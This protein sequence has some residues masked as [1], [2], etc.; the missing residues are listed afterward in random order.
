MLS[1]ALRDEIRA[2][3]IAAADRTYCQMW[4]TDVVSLP[5][6]V[7]AT[8][9]LLERLTATSV[10]RQMQSLGEQQPDKLFLLVVEA[11]ASIYRVTGREWDRSSETLSAPIAQVVFARSELASVIFRLVQRLFR[12]L[13]QIESAGVETVNVTI[14]AGELLPSDSP[15]AALPPGMFF[16]PFFRYLDRQ[17]HVRSIQTVPWT[18]LRLNS[19][20]RAK[21]VCDL[22]T[23]LRM[24]LG[25]GRRRR[26]EVQAI[27]LHATFGQTRLELVNQLNRSKRLVGYRVLVFNK[28]PQPRKE[29]DQTVLPQPLIMLS[30]RDGTVVI[31]VEPDHPVRWVYVQSGKNLLAR[32]PI[33]PGVERHMTIAVPDDSLQ[34]RVQG[35]LTR[36]ET[37]LIDVVAQ[38][39]VLMALL[40]KFA[41]AGKWQQVDKVLAELDKLPTKRYFQSEL[42][43]IRFPAVTEAEKRRLR[44]A[45]LRIEKECRDVAELIDHHLDDSKLRDVKSEVDEL[46]KALQKDQ[47]KS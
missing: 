43:A 25:S 41:E 19:T 11:T 24:P 33:V 18:Y 37:R 34:L 47:R 5:W 35:Q 29:G 17:Y 16:Q 15:D 32:V 9:A 36:L 14:R 27:A 4:K 7:P 1:P 2:E 31:P 20:N 10:K 8:G 22:V 3:L 28:R 45:K 44:V 42:Q 23:G 13:L 39:A 40:Q 12:P 21:A 26:V 6:L 38:R 46:R 30:D